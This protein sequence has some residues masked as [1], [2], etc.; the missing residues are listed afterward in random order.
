MADR[1]DG[2]PREE[3]LTLI[4]GLYFEWM[5]DPEP[6]VLEPRLLRI[7]DFLQGHPASRVELVEVLKALALVWP[8]ASIEL[9]EFAMASLRWPEI[10]EALQEYLH[11]TTQLERRRPAERVLLA[12]EDHWANAHLYPSFAAEQPRL[13]A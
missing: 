6:D 12:Y 2:T 4:N 5:R 13:S 1:L 11:V 10:E 3:L 7:V 8:P 9:L